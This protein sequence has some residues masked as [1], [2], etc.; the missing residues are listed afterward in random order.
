MDLSFLDDPEFFPR[1]MK[2]IK[3]GT[4]SIQSEERERERANALA[5]I[6]ARVPPEQRVTSSGNIEL[7]FRQHRTDRI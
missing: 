1:G 5:E 3:R 4:R 7:I 6:L 2:G